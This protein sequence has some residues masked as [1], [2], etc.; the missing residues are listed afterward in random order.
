MLTNNLEE[1]KTI[2]PTAAPRVPI[3]IIGFLPYLS[4]KTP[5]IMAEHS[6]AAQNDAA[7]PPG[8][9]KPQHKKKQRNKN[10]IPA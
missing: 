10:G 1:P 7:K 6:C 9:K 4:L 3:I 5:H 8:F 2:L